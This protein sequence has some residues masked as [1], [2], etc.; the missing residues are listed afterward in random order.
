MI[1]KII[2]KWLFLS[3]LIFPLKGLATPEEQ[4]AEQQEES[5]TDVV[6]HHIADS[7]E[8]HLFDWNQESITLPLPIILWTENG[9]VTFLSNEFHH[10]DSGKVVV[11]KAGQYFVCIHGQIYY[12]DAQGNISYNKEHKVT[13]AR[14]LD[15]SITKNVVVLFLIAIFMFLAFTALA[16]SYKKNPKAPKGF[17]NLLETLVVFVRDD[18]AIP[19]I[20]GKKYER[21]MPYLLTVFFL[22][23][24]GNLLGLV[25]IISG[26]LTNDIVFTGTLA[27]LTFL[28]TTFSGNGNYWK[29]IFATPGVPMWLAPIMIPVEVIGMLTKPFSLMIRLFANI[30]AGHIIILSLIGLIF[31]FKTLLVSPVSVGFAL[32]I[33]ILELLVAFIQAYVFTLLSAL[34]IG[35][36]VA[37]EHH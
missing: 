30:T 35:G 17:A 24:L 25:P 31:T 21:Y 9:L 32:F 16:R 34:F 4:P 3:I 12:T 37:E 36:A 13:N 28:I 27:L 10:D 7:H 2:S 20:G 29:H 22:I 5:F 8:Y 15:F 23:L 19:N 14:P 33:S 26:T 18:I 1:Q 6:M 11:E